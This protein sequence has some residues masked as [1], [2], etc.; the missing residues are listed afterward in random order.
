LAGPWA[1]IASRT[2]TGIGSGDP[3][4]AAKAVANLLPDVPYLPARSIAKNMID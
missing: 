2:A 4:K 3:K 1:T